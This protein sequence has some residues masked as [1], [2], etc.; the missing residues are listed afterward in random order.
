M[1]RERR[2]QF[3]LEW[4]ADVPEVGRVFGLGIDPNWT[5]QLAPE[6]L[7]QFDHFIEGWNGE[8]PVIGVRTKWKPFVRA[9]GPDLGEREIFGEPAG[10]G[11]PVDGLRRA[12]G[13]KLHRH[14]R[15]ATD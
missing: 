12:T 4:Q 15:G 11:L 7:R 5:L 3:V 9:E 6:P 13:G 1:L 10:D 8:L 2:D 14:V